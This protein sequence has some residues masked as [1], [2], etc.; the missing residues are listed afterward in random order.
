MQKKDKLFAQNHRSAAHAFV[1]Q[2]TLPTTRPATPS[3]HNGLCARLRRAAH[4]MQFA[5]LATGIFTVTALFAGVA[6]DTAWTS[7]ATWVGVIAGL[8]LLVLGIL[9]RNIAWFLDPNDDVPE[10]DQDAEVRTRATDRTYALLSWPFFPVII[11]AV[12]LRERSRAP[13]VSVSA[14]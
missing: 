1:R 9:L 12:W 13:E 11:L 10:I 6:Q 2:L 8:V 7:T 5:V 3:I 4:N 14:N